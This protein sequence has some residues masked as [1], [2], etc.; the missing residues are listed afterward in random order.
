[1][2]GVL[3]PLQEPLKPTSTVAPGARE[4]FQ[5]M[6]VAVTAAPSWR[7]VAFHPWVTC[8]PAGKVKESS[9]LESGAVPW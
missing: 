9:Q 4:L 8:W 7:H 3:L 1:M 6:G 2:G 5:D